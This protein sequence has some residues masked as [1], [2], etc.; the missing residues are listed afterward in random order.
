M[1]FKASARDTLFKFL[2]NRTHSKR[3][4]YMHTS[5][6]THKKLSETYEKLSETYEKLT[7]TY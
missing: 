1:I 6:C 7:H 4:G 3:G 2:H 5:T